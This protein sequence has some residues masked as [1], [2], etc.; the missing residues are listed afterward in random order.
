MINNLNR[1]TKEIGANEELLSLIII[2]LEDWD[3]KMQIE[4]AQSFIAPLKD[5]L[6]SKDNLQ[7]LLKLA[8]M[9]VTNELQEN[10]VLKDAWTEVF[11]QVVGQ[12]DFAYVQLV[13]L[14]EI[15]ELTD[16][17]SKFERRKLGNR[18]LTSLI[19]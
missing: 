9:L 3:N 4:C 17:K 18:L 6:L 15:A 14:K 12:V 13:A 8:V 10:Q 5:K 16:R 19:K 2:S 1:Y 7:R 11:D